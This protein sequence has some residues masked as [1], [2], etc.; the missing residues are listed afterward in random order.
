MEINSSVLLLILASFV[1]IVIAIVQWLKDNDEE[2][3]N[4][5]L[6]NNL[7][8]FC[9]IVASIAACIAGLMSSCEQQSSEIAS[10]NYRK[11]SDSLQVENYKLVNQIKDSTNRAMQISIELN[12]AQQTI[13]GLQNSTLEYVTGGDNKPM[14]VN[15]VGQMFSP[16]KNEINFYFHLANSGKTVLHDISIT[17]RDIYQEVDRFINSDSLG[18][19][20]A[21]SKNNQNKMIHVGGNYMLADISEYSENRKREFDD[22]LSINQNRLFNIHLSSLDKT[23]PQTRTVYQS[24]IPSGAK[25]YHFVALVEWGNGSYTTKVSYKEY[26]SLI[27]VK[28]WALYDK[29]KRVNDIF[30]YFNVPYPQIPKQLIYSG[31][32]NYGEDTFSVYWNSIDL[33][34]ILIS[35]ASIHAQSFFKYRPKNPKEALVAAKKSLDEILGKP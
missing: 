18:N 6:A 34:I 35:R 24:H 3:P 27:Y 33:N 14:L 22:I 9:G 32:V 17:I 15:T 10:L 31:K 16:D 30:K 4:K 8:L 1:A 19:F 26:D 2:K 12:K 13:V 5:R 20:S 28:K 25:M 29:G 7:L 23:Y 21:V 11:K